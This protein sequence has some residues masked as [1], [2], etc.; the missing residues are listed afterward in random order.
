MKKQR[1]INKDIARTRTPMP[2]EEESVKEL[3]AGSK[4]RSAREKKEL[5]R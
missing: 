1:K 3:E 4:R 5:K 2:R